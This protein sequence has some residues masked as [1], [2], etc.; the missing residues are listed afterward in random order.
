MTV[1]LYE[2]E[3]ENQERNK[4]TESR[5]CLRWSCRP[6]PSGT[7]KRLYSPCLTRA[8]PPTGACSPLPQGLLLEPG[9]WSWSS[10]FFPSPSPALALLLLLNPEAETWHEAVSLRW[11][12]WRCE[13]E[14]LGE[15]ISRGKSCADEHVPS[16]RSRGPPAGPTA[17]P[18]TRLTT[19][20]CS[21]GVH[22]PLHLPRE[23]LSRERQ[24]FVSSPPEP[25]CLTFCGKFW[26][27]P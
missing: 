14:A 23:E 24:T 3:S 7:E 13:G 1:D 22:V 9:S 4:D 2:K 10:S 5:A 26:T 12:S 19:V 8:R 16:G 25:H 18:E 15:D 20:L 11:L 27:I 17:P 6:L 21:L